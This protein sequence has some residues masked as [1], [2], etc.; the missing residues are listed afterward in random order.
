MA[1][2]ADALRGVEEGEVIEGDP[3]TPEQS[4]AEEL[5]KHEGKRR[6]T[7]VRPCVSPSLKKLLEGGRQRKKLERFAIS[8]LDAHAYRRRRIRILDIFEKSR[9]KSFWCRFPTI[10]IIGSNRFFRKPHAGRYFI[11]FRAPPSLFLKGRN[12]CF[13][14]D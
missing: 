9:S 7:K 11:L 6:R 3:L 5:E 12:G 4:K 13:S 1:S 8:K 10:D 14:E 2:M